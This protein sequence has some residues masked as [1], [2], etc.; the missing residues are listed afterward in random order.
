MK[1]SQLNINSL[2][3]HEYQRWYALM[4]EEGKARVDRFYFPDDKKRTIVEELLARK[5]ISDWCGVPEELIQ[6]RRT[7]YGK[8]FAAGPPVE[9][10][11]RSMIEK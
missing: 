5:A 9:F 7:K 10:N 6:F 1:W 8:P 2:S 4:D 3:D 11:S